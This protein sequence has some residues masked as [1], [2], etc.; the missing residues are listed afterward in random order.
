MRSA[1]GILIGVALN[2]PGV[3]G[4]E[5]GAERRLGGEGVTVT[6]QE[7][8]L[9]PLTHLAPEGAQG[10]SVACMDSVSPLTQ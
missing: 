10:A 4:Q 5:L 1:A 9:V 7:K 6:R 8:S 2:Q 3:A